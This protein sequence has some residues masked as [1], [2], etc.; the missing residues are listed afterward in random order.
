MTYADLREIFYDREAEFRDA[1]LTAHIVFAED[2]FL[3]PVPRLSR[4]YRVSSD[5]SA[6]RPMADNYSITGICLDGVGQLTNLEAYLKE[7]CGGKSSWKVDHCY[8]LDHMRDAYA[9]PYLSRLTQKDGTICYRFGST[10]IQVRENLENGKICLQPVEGT[11]VECNGWYTLQSD[12][13]KG[14]CYLLERAINEKGG[15]NDG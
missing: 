9:I 12:L 8:I 4:V 13:V 7:E 11:Q 1:P 2:N 14:Y 6:Y 10:N 15:K 3:E 5:N